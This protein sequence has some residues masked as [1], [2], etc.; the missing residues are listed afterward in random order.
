[1]PVTELRV[2][3]ENAWRATDRVLIG[4]PWPG[5]VPVAGRY[6]SGADGRTEAQK[7]AANVTRLFVNNGTSITDVLADPTGAR[8]WQDSANNTVWVQAVGG[9]ALNV[10]GYDGRSEDSLKRHHYIR[11]RPGP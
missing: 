3:L 5:N 6:D 8:I 11:L 7:L 1:M 2:A 10:Y 9:M 4:L